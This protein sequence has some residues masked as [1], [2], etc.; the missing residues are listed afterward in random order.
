MKKLVASFTVIIY[1]IFACGVMVNYHYCMDRYDSFSLYKA[2]GDWCPK[3]QMHTNGQGCCHDE[4]KIVK[5]QN[6]YQTSSTT[7][8]FKDIQPA[9]VTLSEFLFV[10]PSDEDISLN[11]TDHSPP[12]LSHQDI[13]I[14]NRVFRI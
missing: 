6:D 13:Y 8:A 5:L 1:F 3:C 7:F 12:L 2:A 14:Q 9:I 10:T 4:I 11:K